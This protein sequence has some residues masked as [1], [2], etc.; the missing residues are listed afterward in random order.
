MSRK[1][2]AEVLPACL[3]SARHHSV[4]V[5]SG[6]CDREKSDS[7]K[8]GITSA[9]IVRNNEGLISHLVG[10]RLERSACT[11]GRHENAL[12]CAVLAVLLLEKL[13]EDAEGDRRLGGRRISR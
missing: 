10:E 13:T 2:C 11:V 1:R 4:D 7:G 5:A 12:A 9:D 6:N 3:G 8:N